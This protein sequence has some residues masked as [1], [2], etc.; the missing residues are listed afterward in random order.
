MPVSVSQRI[1]NLLGG[2]S[3]QPDSLKLPGQVTQ[4]DNCLPDPTYGLL[5]RPG[6][7]LVSSLNGATA[8]G[9]WF[10]I[11]RDSQEKYIGQFSPTGTLR[12]WNANNGSALVV[13]AVTAAAQNYVAGLAESDFEMLQIND[14][15]FVLNRT[16]TVAALPTLSPTSDPEAI[17]VLRVAGYDSKYTITLDGTEYS[18]TTPATGNVSIKS[19]IDGIASALPAAYT[20][21]KISN[22]IHITR[23][24]NADFTVEAKGGLTSVS[25][26]AFKTSVR[27]VADLPGSCIDGMVLKIQNLENLDGDEYYV[28]FE[29]NGPQTKGVGS[30]TETVAPGIV[31]TLDPDT[32]P[33]AVIRESD[34][35]FT[36]RSLNEADKDG[37]DLYWVE[38]RVGDD[39]SNPMPTFVGQKVT[40]ISFFRNRL[41]L[42]AGSNVICSQP[43]NFFNLFRVSA[44]TTSDA[45]AVDLA[46]G[47]L[48][49]VSLRYALGDQLGLLIFS[50]HSQ[51]MLSAEGDTFGPA[52]AQLK[53]FSTLTINP[54]VSPVDTGTSIIYVDTNQGFSTVTE[55]LVTSAENRPQQA[56][57]S[58]TAPNF[59]P[60][61]LQSMVSNPSASVVTLLGTQN[62]KELYIFKYFNNGNERVLAS[63]IRWLLPG[64]CLLQAGDHDKYYFVTEQENGVCLST[65]TVLVDVEG[66]AINQNGISYEYRMDLFTSSMT[67]AYDFA[68]DTTRVFF[69]TGTYDS[70]L[71]PV[72]VVDD[73]ST[74]KGVLYINPNYVSNGAQNYVEIPGNRLTADQITLGYQYQMTVG[75]PR[76]YRRALQPGGGVESDVVNIPR[77]QRV[78]IQSTDSGPFTASV[79]LKGRT[80]KTYSFP[81][82]IANEYILNTVPLP[83]IIDNTIPVYGKGTDVDVTLSSNTPFPLSFIAATWFGLYANRGIQS[84]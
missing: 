57:L 14:Y 75:I 45:D 40:G 34:G 76:F 64:N 44:L 55:M 52:S 78:V 51:F 21:T 6:T 48:R 28:K 74:E 23:T 15:N 27:D 20:K 2:V 80:T 60:G 13:N 25:V 26:E 53:A 30:W 79:A 77:V 72:V 50:E 32:M 35:T 8:D 54:N 7:K 67:T 41:V 4:A 16:K 63:W 68:S 9:R 33:H 65:C 46:S 18:Y 39:D 47:S 5:K 12:I 1:P 22:V 69:P 49:P 81:Q 19:V 66:T 73:T 10:T 59:V 24:D 83:E 58:R 37:D 62:A 84:I 38:R 29:T 61:S 43:S 82:A 36:F 71:V 70:S 42:L 31:T 3:Q 56:D 11:F 17:I